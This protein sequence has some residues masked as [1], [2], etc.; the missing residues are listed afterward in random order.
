MNWLVS[1]LSVLGQ[2]QSLPVFNVNPDLFPSDCEFFPFAIHLTRS[3]LQRRPSS[4]K[5]I[6]K[7]RKILTP[8]HPPHNLKMVRF[9]IFVTLDK[10]SLSPFVRFFIISFLLEGFPYSLMYV[11]VLLAEPL[12]NFTR[13]MKDMSMTTRK[14]CVLGGGRFPKYTNA[15]TLPTSASHKAWLPLRV[16]CCIYPLYLLSINCHCFS[17]LLH[18]EE[19]QLKL[20]FILLIGPT[21]AKF[22]PSCYLTAFI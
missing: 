5:E 9:I 4:N 10:L 20:V 22:S 18:S 12:C 7:N 17:P 14:R 3:H 2:D 6:M 16:N 21:L 19:S 8:T 13:K 15:Q 1:C 11:E